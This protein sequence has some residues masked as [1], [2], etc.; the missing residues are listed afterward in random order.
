MCWQ[1]FS[2]DDE[3]EEDV[4]E[5]NQTATTPTARPRRLSELNLPEKKRPIPPAS[6]LFVFSSTNK[7]RMLCWKIVNHSY[8]GNVILACILISSLMLAAED[9]LDAKSK[10]NTI[11]NYFDYIF[12]SIFTIEI[13]IKV[14]IVTVLGTQLQFI[15]LEYLCSK[16]STMG[17]HL[18]IMSI[19]TT[20]MTFCGAQCNAQSY[21]LVQS[22]RL[23]RMELC[24]TRGHS[25]ATHSTCWIY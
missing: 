3:D 9:P 23:W 15:Y 7:F 21:L 13:L 25:A 24:F 8:F 12:T 10:R 11:L 1:S 17:Q 19:S 5:D 14:R 18:D 22:C 6:S 16:L 2:E 20:L 4:E